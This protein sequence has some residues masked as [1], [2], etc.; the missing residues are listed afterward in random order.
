MTT[1]SPFP[2]RRALLLAVAANIMFVAPT[3]S[4]QVLQRRFD[5]DR[6]G[7][8]RVI[9][10][11]DA[12]KAGNAEACDPKLLSVGPNGEVYV[13]G[14]LP[15][16]GPPSG[17]VVLRVTADGLEQ[18]G[19]Q[20]D[21][22]PGAF[23]TR[24][25]GS[26]L[27]G[28]RG[29][30][31]ARGG[32]LLG[33]DEG[34]WNLLTSSSLPDEITSLL[35]LDG[36]VLVGAKNDGVYRWSAD[37]VERVGATT[38]IVPSGFVW[39]ALGDYTAEQERI[40]A[41]ADGALVTLGKDYLVREWRK[42]GWSTLGDLAK[43]TTSELGLV[44]G[45]REYKSVLVTPDDALYV[46][47]KGLAGA[48][49]GKDVG[50][51]FRWTGEDWARVG[52]NA[53]LKKEAKQ[54]LW[55]E[56]FGL[57]VGTNE[58]GVFRLV[59]EEWVALNEGLVA[60]ADGKI[61]GERLASAPDGSLYV[62]ATNALYRRSADATAF[63]QVGFFPLGQEIKSIGFVGTGVYVGTKVGADQGAVYRL[64]G[65]SEWTQLGA[66]LSKPVEQLVAV[67]ND[68][69]YA[70][71]GGGAGAVMW[72][73]ATWTPMTGALTGVAA[74]FKH[75]LR[76]SPSEFA[77]A[78]KSGVVV[79]DFRKEP[80]EVID[81]ALRNREVKSLIHAGGTTLAVTKSGVFGLVE[82]AETDDGLGWVEA[83]KGLPDVELEGAVARDEEVFV[84]GKKL[85]YSGA[86]EGGVLE[87]KP[88]G[89]NPG[90]AALDG[91][92]N[93]IY[94]GETEF[95]GVA[96]LAD[97]SPLAATKDGL[98]A[99]DRD[100]AWTLYNGPAEVKAVATVGDT[101]YAIVKEKWVPDLDDPTTV[102][103]ET[104]LW[105]SGPETAVE[106]PGAAGRSNGA[107]GESTNSGATPSKGGSKNG[108][109]SGANDDPTH[110]DDKAADLDATG[111]QCRAAGHPAGGLG[112]WWLLVGAVAVG[113][114]RASRL[115]TW[116]TSI[117]GNLL[118]W[119][120]V[121]HRWSGVV[122]ALLVLGEALTG[123]FLL[124]KDGLWGVGNARV[125]HALLPSWYAKEA[126][127]SRLEPR[128]LVTD[129]ST[130][131]HLVLAAKHALF[132]S[133]DGGAHWRPAYATAAFGEVNG[134]AFYRNSLWVAHKL[135]LA[136][137]QLAV[138]CQAMDLGAM[139]TWSKLEVRA[140]LV[141]PD[142]KLYV[143]AH[144]GPILTSRDGATFVDETGNLAGVAG[145][146][147][148]EQRTTVHAAA[149][150]GSTLYLAGE[151][152]VV[153]LGGGFHYSS[154][155]LSDRE[156]RQMV[157]VREGSVWALVKGMNGVPGQVYESRLERLDWRT[158]DGAGVSGLRL[159]SGEH[160]AYLASASAILRLEPGRSPTELR[161]FKET[162][163]GERHDAP[164]VASS[165]ERIFAIGRDGTVSDGLTAASFV[166]ATPPRT[167]GVELKKIMDDLHTGKFFAGKLILLYDLLAL[168][169]V[170]FVITGIHLW[171][172]PQLIK[173]RRSREAKTARSAA[174][175]TS[176]KPRAL[177]AT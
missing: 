19:E 32:E 70:A 6:H 74:E 109:S 85:L 169:L 107:G 167:T 171:L 164:L 33:L 2:L 38:T 112:G 31:T 146:L 95:K 50:A 170:L 52:T 88:L 25:D 15:F 165:G 63:A 48:P 97:G 42:D 57:V 21:S 43:V 36:Q 51:V 29:T 111:C 12:A 84:I 161:K 82:Q 86:V 76:L 46:G 142:H 162:V 168:S 72:N 173:W 41:R 11:G 44:T 155:G 89:D 9:P 47:T 123:F 158:V 35:E 149:L 104:S 137:C 37:K 8:W 91:D 60:N 64:D 108:N 177:E 121:T 133:D 40:A 148:K 18:V 73:G 56:A 119:S 115:R 58:G 156:V 166:G 1:Q 124:H 144:K 3:V 66:D 77:A 105:I 101:V 172:A 14:K 22:D 138:G 53:A 10:M 134:L 45:L 132:E 65:P 100:G 113:A 136:R 102:K 61:K 5:P 117:K 163:A 34:E 98:F 39:E 129:P 128:A 127:D 120:R 153:R 16:A 92:G 81:L 135:G 143:V 87:V 17:G 147:D 125:P 176:R 126:E 96:F 13:L 94:A 79:G 75:I 69:M 83:S 106:P 30:A 130:P 55:S 71:L 174:A 27:L 54:L 103:E 114:R 80:L 24:S 20:T 67:A 140:V 150:V 62:A 139:G 59:S 131:E 157:G 28:G 154:A 93:L 7:P 90:T 23:L 122:L 152:G 159:S 4:A 151:L 175:P 26:F 118:K 68:E 141:S 78:T 110:E 160:G 145:M 99:R 116:W 49:E